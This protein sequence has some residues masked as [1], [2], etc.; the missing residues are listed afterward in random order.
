MLDGGVLGAWRSVLAEPV[1]QERRV[2]DP[3]AS[4]N[5]ETSMSAAWSANGASTSIQ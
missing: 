3:E 4:L 1:D 5:A 2:H